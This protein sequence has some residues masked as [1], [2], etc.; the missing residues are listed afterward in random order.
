MA[1]TDLSEVAVRSG[2]VQRLILSDLLAIL[3]RIHGCPATTLFTLMGKYRTGVIHSHVQISL[4][5]F[6]VQVE[7]LADAQEYQV[8][9]TIAGSLPFSVHHCLVNELQN[10]PVVVGIVLEADRNPETEGPGTL[11]IPG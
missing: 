3:Q 7:L 4:Q 11:R 1:V 8:I 5:A 10:Y 6:R 9:R 2:S